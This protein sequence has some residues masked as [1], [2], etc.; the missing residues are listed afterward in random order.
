MVDAVD[1]TRTGSRHADPGAGAVR[2]RLSWATTLRQSAGLWAMLVWLVRLWIEI[3]TERALL[4]LRDAGQEVQ[5]S[6][7]LANSALGIEDRDNRHGVILG[8]VVNRP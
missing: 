5:R 8:L 4:A 7:C 3:E 1:K 2:P 6:G